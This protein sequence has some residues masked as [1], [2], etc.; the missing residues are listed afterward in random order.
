MNCP[1]CGKELNVVDSRR[2]GGTVRRR[3]YCDRCKF[4]TTTY[5]ITME[6]MNE[7]R[8]LER[9]KADILTSIRGIMEKYELKNAGGIENE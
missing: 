8:K 7:F 6:E 1:L 4:R 2:I 9:E 3:R 5:E